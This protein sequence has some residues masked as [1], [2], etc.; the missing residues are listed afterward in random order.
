MD[1]SSS[2]GQGE[3]ISSPLN[4]LDLNELNP[5]F[6]TGEV[7]YL[8]IYNLNFVLF[9]SLKDMAHNVTQLLAQAEGFGIQ[10]R[11]FCLLDKK[12]LLLSN[13]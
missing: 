9:Q 3:I 1:I 2:Y 4:S 11:L 8:L 7:K 6:I 5:T 13:D 12:Y 10:L